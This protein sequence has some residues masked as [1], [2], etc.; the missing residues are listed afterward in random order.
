MNQRLKS[1]TLLEENITNIRDIGTGTDFLKMSQ[2]AQ[3]RKAST[4]KWDYIILKSFCAAK[5]K[6][7]Q[8]TN[9]K[10]KPKQT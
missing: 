1:F 6:K 5:G 2:L 4:D 3:Q 8:P 7:I 10:N 9:Q